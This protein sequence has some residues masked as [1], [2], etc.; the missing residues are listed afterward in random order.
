M[1]APYLNLGSSVTPDKRRRT[2]DLLAPRAWEE[3]AACRTVND[4]AKLTAPE[5]IDACRTACAHRLACYQL[6]LDVATTYGITGG[7]TRAHDV[8][9]G[10]VTLDQIAR[11]TR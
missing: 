4:W 9:Y 6:G 7:K 1:S 2:L 8:V 10:G 5:Q 11:R 3:H